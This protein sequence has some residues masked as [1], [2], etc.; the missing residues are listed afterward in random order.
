MTDTAIETAVTQQKPSRHRFNDQQQENIAGWLMVSP[1]ILLILGFL[2][3]PFLMA[4]GLAF[5]NQRLISPNP[6]EYVGGRNFARLLTLRTLAID[7]LV[8]ETTGELAC[9]EDGNLTYPRTR[10]FTRN[11]PDYRNWTGCKSGCPKR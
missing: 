8:D 10:A 7:P 5:T 11:N 3:V 4:F 9:D 1:A 6:T 2:I